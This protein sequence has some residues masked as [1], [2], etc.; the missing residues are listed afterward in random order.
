MN[1]LTD[2]EIKYIQE[3]PYGLEIVMDY[4]DTQMCE[5]MAMGFDCS[6]HQ[7]RYDELKEERDRLLKVWE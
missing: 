3:S 2:S 6:F 1:K 4:H 5:G 7:K